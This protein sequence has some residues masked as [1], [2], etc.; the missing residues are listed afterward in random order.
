MRTVGQ[1]EGE[2]TYG[3]MYKDMDYF[4]TKHAVT[5]T[6]SRGDQ[7]HFSPAFMTWHSLFMLEFENS[8]LA[9]DPAIEG[10]PYWDS[11]D[12]STSIFTNE[13]MGSVPG[14]GPSSTVIDGRFANWPVHSEPNWKLSN[15]QKYWQHPEFV[16]FVN[17][18]TGFLRQTGNF[19][20]NPILTRYGEEFQYSANGM[21]FSSNYN[22]Y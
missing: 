8:L 17:S 9:V 13:Y 3:P 5:A 19:N 12:N 21:L 10:L 20:D 1:E 2:I 15:Y 4:I 7:G 16:N 6:D 18:D 22:C 11:T 14:T